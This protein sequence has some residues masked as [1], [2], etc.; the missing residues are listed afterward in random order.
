MKDELM[1]VYAVAYKSNGNYQIK[2]VD[3]PPAN[4][5]D[6]AK[7]IEPIGEGRQLVLWVPEGTPGEEAQNLA[8]HFVPQ[9]RN[10]LQP[11]EA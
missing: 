2:L 3:S 7:V 1:D 5:D 11:V 4:V 8:T 10:M 9:V 6:F